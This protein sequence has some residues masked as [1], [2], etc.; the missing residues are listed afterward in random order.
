MAPLLHHLG[1]QLDAHTQLR[2]LLSVVLVIVF[3]E[4]KHEDVDSRQRVGVSRR[5][6]EDSR[7]PCRTR[8]RRSRASSPWLRGT[9]SPDPMVHRYPV[10]GPGPVP[11]SRPALGARSLKFSVKYWVLPVFYETVCGSEQRHDD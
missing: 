8:S 1:R 7:L 11:A 10:L 5:C 3:D 6:K 2:L 9:Q 4:A